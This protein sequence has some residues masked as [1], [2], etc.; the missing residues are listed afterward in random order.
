MA[1]LKQMIVE[2]IVAARRDRRDL[3]ELQQRLDALLQRGRRLDSTDPNQPLLFPEMSEAVPAPAP[4]LPV[5]EQSHRH[6]KRHRHGR[7]RPSR[8]LRHEPRRYELTAAERL[9]PECGVERPEIG[10]ES[11][12]QF[13]YKPAEV[14]W[15]GSVASSFGSPPDSS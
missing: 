8:E 15:I 1:V 14:S 2:L 11:T 6:G 4:P 9:C 10:V 3:A 7:R 12:K 5:E 13:D